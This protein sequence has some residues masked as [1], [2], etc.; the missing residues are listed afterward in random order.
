MFTF[1]LLLLS[2]FVNVNGNVLQRLP[3]VPTS[4][5]SSEPHYTGVFQTTPEFY[6]GEFTR[7]LPYTNLPPNKLPGP[8]PTG[9]AP[10]L[11][12][13]NPAPFASKSYIPNNPL[14]T[15]VPIV[16]NTN[17]ANIYQLH[18]QLSH[19]FPNP[20]GFGVDEFALPAGSNISYLY[21]LSRHGSRYPTT[22]SGAPN[23]AEK[24][25]NASSTLN[26]TGAVSFLNGWTYKLGAEILVPVGKQE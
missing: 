15:Q 21:M 3:S 4:S 22:G 10:F 23:L 1:L 11:A 14:E 6:A 13:S 17:D 24:L 18:G 19:Y 25:K 20:D 12:E 9:V 5:T 16:G 2:G 8:T 26:A 7:V